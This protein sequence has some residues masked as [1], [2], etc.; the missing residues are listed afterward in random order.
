MGSIHNSKGFLLNRAWWNLTGQEY[1]PMDSYAWVDK[2]TSGTKQKKVVIYSVDPYIARK[3]SALQLH[4]LIWINLR[5][6]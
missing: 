2:M 5:K 4:V 6:Q 3:R 1:N